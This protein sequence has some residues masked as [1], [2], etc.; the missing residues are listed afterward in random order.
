MLTSPQTVS[1]RYIIIST[2]EKVLGDAFH[3][4]LTQ[5][6]LTALKK[7]SFPV[8]ELVR[9]NKAQIFTPLEGCL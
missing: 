8:R 5:V 4:V 3:T 7:F 6:R 2:K 9:L 1:N